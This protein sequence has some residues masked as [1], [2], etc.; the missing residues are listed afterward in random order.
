MRTD[1][2]FVG[3]FVG[4]ALLG[5]LTVLGADEAATPFERLRDLRVY[6]IRCGLHGIDEVR[7]ILARPEARAG[8]WECVR[9][10]IRRQKGWDA[11]QHMRL[12]FLSGIEAADIDRLSHLL[13]EHRRKSRVETGLLSAYPRREL[14]LHAPFSL[15]PA[16]ESK[17]LAPLARDAANLF[18][19]VDASSVWILAHRVGPAAV[20]DA[21]AK[22]WKERT[23]VRSGPEEARTAR[24]EL[25]LVPPENVAPEELIYLKTLGTWGSSDGV[26]WP[27]GKV[28]FA[29]YLQ[30]ERRSRCEFS[31]SIPGFY[32][33]SA[34]TLELVAGSTVRRTIT[35]TRKRFVVR[36]SV[37]PAPASPLMVALAQ[38]AP[39]GTAV[40][41]L[42]SHEF[43]GLV[44]ADGHFACPY[45]RQHGYRTLLVCDLDGALLREI[46]CPLP[47]QGGDVDVGAVRLPHPTPY[48]DVPIRLTWDPSIP[49]GAVVSLKLTWVP[50]DAASPKGTTHVTVQSPR[51]TL[52]EPN[53]RI[54][55]ARNLLAGEYDVSVEF[56]AEQ[57]QGKVENYTISYLAK[58]GSAP[59]DIAVH[60]AAGTTP[61]AI[62]NP[63]DHLL[64]DA[65]PAPL[66]LCLRLDGTPVLVWHGRHG[67]F[68]RAGDDAAP[69]P[70][71]VM[72]PAGELPSE[73]SSFLR[74]FADQGNRLHVFAL[75]P[76]A[77]GPR[78]VP[79]YRRFTPEGRPA[80][81]WVRLFTSNAGASSFQSLAV[82]PSKTRDVFDVVAPC[83]ETTRTPGAGIIR[84]CVWLCA[85]VAGDQVSTAGTPPGDIE[86]RQD[87]ADGFVIGASPAR[88]AMLYASNYRLTWASYPHLRAADVGLP[89]VGTLDWI[90]AMLYSS[91]G[92]AYVAYR[93]PKLVK[94]KGD[95]VEGFDVA[96]YKLCVAGGSLGSKLSV[97][98]LAKETHEYSHK[99]ALAESPDG[100]VYLFAPCLPARDSTDCVIGCWK[101]SSTGATPIWTPWVAY[102]ENP[103]RAAFKD[104]TTAYVARIESHKLR[105]GVFSLKK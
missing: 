91:K 73:Q 94:I 62:A 48:V 30:E 35:L 99:C 63:E 45:T 100:N 3:F 40:G 5:I 27:D 102:R 96:H 46:D 22:A 2:V 57:Q 67:L 97:R 47:E 70:I 88:C 66:D 38:A 93:M 58:P 14:L 9:D 21:L 17:L 90:E 41:A 61:G 44:R 71:A 34:F 11:D 26:I 1:G 56:A 64:V 42:E 10:A 81:A 69:G 101:V 74:C 65:S 19:A 95:G 77:D 8:L 59:L 6:D 28:R 37:Q 12:L 18:D 54:G 72:C 55:T 98:F 86:W 33:P 39:H 75:F 20:R 85:H 51:K 52:K 23:P 60:C 82:F 79:Y 83:L 15:T 68:M 87:L 29:R 4:F 43:C 7:G 89:A 80:G 53:A 24:G 31:L 103:L 50:K 16:I 13:E 76:G 92:T 104:A 25:T 32:D 105:V 36:G 78:T 84:N 49:F